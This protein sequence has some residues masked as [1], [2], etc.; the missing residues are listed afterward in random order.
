MQAWL[1]QLVKTAEG[2]KQSASPGG[3]SRPGRKPPVS[4]KQ[5]ITLSAKKKPQ[6]STE[7]LAQE[8][9]FSEA[10]APKPWDTP[11]L[12]VKRKIR[13]KAAAV[14]KKKGKSLAKKALE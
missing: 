8:L 3:P 9:P 11:T 6:V 7:E 1:T 10:S 14:A 13:K 12:A 2:I 4:P 5:S